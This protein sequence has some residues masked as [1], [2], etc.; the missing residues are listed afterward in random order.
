LG[1]AV[2]HVVAFAWGGAH[3][4]ANFA[5]A[6]NKCNA[7]KNDVVAHEF[8]RTA[9]LRTVKGKYGE[10]VAWDGLSTLF[11]ILA[12]GRSDLSASEKGWLAGLS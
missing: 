9:P 10:P 7:R 4:E 6:C 12:Q 8:Q 2:D 3:D 11:V 5:T 1:A